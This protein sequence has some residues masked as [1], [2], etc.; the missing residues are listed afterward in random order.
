LSPSEI[1]EPAVLSEVFWSL[2]NHDEHYNSNMNV[3]S[4]DKAICKHLLK[5]K[6]S[7]S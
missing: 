7:Y 3:T 1:S 6:T 4:V 2:G 5:S